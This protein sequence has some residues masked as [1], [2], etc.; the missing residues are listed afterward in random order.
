LFG[1][2]YYKAKTLVRPVTQHRRLFERAKYLG[3][4]ILPPQEGNDL[5]ARSIQRPCAIGKIGSGEMAA[6]RHYLSRS[7][8]SGN[9][10]SWGWQTTNLYQIA[11]VYPPE[12]G[13][14]SRFCKEFAQALTH[15]DVLAVWFN[16]GEHAA[17][18][19]FAPKATLTALRAL[20][21]F[22]HDRPWSQ[23][24]A[25][26]RVLV[27]SPFADTIQAQ[28]QRRQQIWRK[29]PETLPDFQLLT[30]RSPLSA[31][32]ATPAYP[33]WCAALDVMREQMASIACDVAIV[34]A[35]AW[36]LPLVAHAKSLGACAIHLGGG[37]QL[38]FGIKGGRWDTHPQISAYFN[39]AWTRPSLSETPQ[40]VQKIEGGC[41]W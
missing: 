38:L 20:E 7:D 40:G 14:F 8:A 9:C 5:I 41:Y 12:P 3:T 6:L 34:G 10:E 16:L 36:S 22:Y 19:R 15:L 4:E 23:H 26:K 37:T 2:I 28:Y 18:R 31:F 29:K 30:L 1:D 21:P 25:G 35:G 27:V 13:I 17:H 11:G 39:E 32:L 24:L 33:D